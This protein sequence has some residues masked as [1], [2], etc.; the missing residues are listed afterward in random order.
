MI[1]TALLAK[2]M[3]VTPSGWKKHAGPFA[4][5]IPRSVADINSSESLT[6]VRAWKKA[7]KAAGKTKQE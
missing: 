2:R 4:D 6:E 5:K 7:Q 1:F 3:G